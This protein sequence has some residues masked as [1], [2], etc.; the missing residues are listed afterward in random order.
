MWL[1]TKYGM[2]SAVLDVPKDG[3]T[4]VEPMFKVRARDVAH[5]EAL[6]VRFPDLLCD[7]EITESAN[8]D[9]RCRIIVPRSVWV[10][11]VTA[12]TLE[13]M[14][15]NFK[16]EVLRSQGPSEYE[17]SLHEVWNVGYRLQERKYGRGI[18]SRYWR[19]DVEPGIFEG[20]EAPPHTPFPL[21]PVRELG[22][23]EIEAGDDELY[24]L[25]QHTG[26]A[27]AWG[28]GKRGNRRGVKGRKNMTNEPVKPNGK[29]GLLVEDETVIG[30][31]DAA[32]GA[33]VIRSKTVEGKADESTIPTDKREK[34]KA[35]GK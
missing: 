7:A 14:Y 19:D 13:V 25:Q 10:N 12:L 15:S 9:Y 11:V 23:A 33:S 22:E 28:R 8:T 30:G 20:A 32:T 24:V 3:E 6:K 29:R 4:R 34:S 27:T 21:V 1:F 26:G 35:V 5:L 17:R 2:F 16:S 31:T 18:Y